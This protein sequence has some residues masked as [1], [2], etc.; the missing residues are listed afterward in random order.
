MSYNYNSNATKCNKYI[1]NGTKVAEN[2][3]TLNLYV[4]YKSL[5]KERCILTMIHL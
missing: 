1:T 5:V 2:G 3:P 4:I